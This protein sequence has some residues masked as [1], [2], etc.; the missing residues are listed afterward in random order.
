MACDQ[1]LN[2][3]GGTLNGRARPKCN[4]VGT[5]GLTSTSSTRP[6]SQDQ[7]GV[8]FSNLQSSFKMTLCSSFRT[9]CYKNNLNTDFGILSSMLSNVDRSKIKCPLI[10][11]R[12]VP[13]SNCVIYS[14]KQFMKIKIYRLKIIEE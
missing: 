6:M 2:R 12:A 11:N 1:T 8:W 13:Y 5:R 3:R 9:F 4:Q 10:K 7:F 14:L